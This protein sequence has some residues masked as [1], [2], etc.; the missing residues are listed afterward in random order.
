MLTLLNNNI[1][2]YTLKNKN[3]AITFIL[4]TFL[5]TNGFKVE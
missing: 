2:L 3:S 4:I 1:V 5:V